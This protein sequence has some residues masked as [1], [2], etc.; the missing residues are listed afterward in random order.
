VSSILVA[1]SLAGFA[2]RIERSIVFVHGLCGHCTKTW[3]KD[4]V[5]WPKDLLS[6]EEALSH[7][8]VLT[9][10]YDAYVV[11]ASLKFQPVRT[12]NKFVE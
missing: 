4:N 1:Y 11:N 2:N 5:C 3:T 9:F 6:K 8:R 10:G 12:L 7:T